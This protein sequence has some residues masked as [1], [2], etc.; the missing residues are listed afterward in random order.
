MI[1]KKNLT[2]IDIFSSGARVRVR[3]C[4]TDKSKNIG[5]D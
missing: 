4:V 1:F 5:K 2:E 3:S